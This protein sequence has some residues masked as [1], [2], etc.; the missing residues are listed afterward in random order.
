MS[1]ASRQIVSSTSAASWPATMRSR[2]PAALCHRDTVSRKG[3]RL[4]IP[5][6][7]WHRGHRRHAFAPLPLRRRAIVIVA[8]NNEQFARLCEVLG[9]GERVS[10]PRFATLA[11]RGRNRQPLGAVLEPAIAARK[12][13]SDLPVAL[14]NA[15]LP[16]GPVCGLAQVSTIGR[17]E[18]AACRRPG[19]LQ[20]VLGL[21]SAAI[22]RLAAAGAI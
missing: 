8:G 9:C 6:R 4:D 12:A 21:E 11:L 16:A 2:I 1:Q 7:R 5:V 15:G 10:D 22:G 14:E 19:M 13:V 20:E 18:R 17:C 3:Q